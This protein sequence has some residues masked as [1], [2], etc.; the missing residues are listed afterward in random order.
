[1]ASIL[2][3]TFIASSGKIVNSMLGIAVTVAL[4][5]L[6]SVQE[7]GVFVVL[8]SYGL[9][10]QAVA[11]FGLYLVLTK[12]LGK[13]ENGAIHPE[14]IS[15]IIALRLWLLLIAFAGAVMISF[16][17]PSVHQAQYFL[18]A[19]IVGLTVQSLSQL[20][21]GV[22]QAYQYMG[23][24]TAGDTVGRLAQLVLIIGIAIIGGRFVFLEKGLLVA[25]LSFLISTVA[26]YLVHWWFVPV[27]GRISLQISWS[28]AR[29]ILQ[30]SWPLALLLILN[31]V[32]FR[33]DMVMLSVLR[34]PLEV[35]YYAVA[36]R[37]IENLLFFPAMFGGLL[38]PTLSRFIHQ[39]EM[40]LAKKIVNQAILVG[41]MMAG[42]SA[43]VLL[44]ASEG[45]IE[46]LSGVKFLPA[47][48]L[49]A[50]LGL[51][52][53]IM[54]IGNVIGFVLVA[55]NKQRQLLWLY[56]GLVMFTCIANA[57]FIPRFGALAAAWVT[58]ATEALACSGALFL[59]RSAVPYR[60]ALTDIL[61]VAAAAGLTFLIISWLHTF[62]PIWISLP[63]GVLSYGFF[64]YVFGLLEKKRFSLLL[65]SSS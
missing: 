40:D 9:L 3:N 18:L 24:A 30:E 64:N 49:L 58:V 12:E 13:Q 47:A 23:P 10:F 52:L 51:A 63:I 43:A 15:N 60:L 26:A 28:V 29:N 57:I 61:F 59:A 46:L 5:R 41:L 53:A 14:T 20:Y 27:K 45:I 11:D 17:I 56:A 38:L 65:Q 54:M 16:F 48:P 62:S 34:S 39:S 44:S 1:M 2:T 25:V 37:I 19:I 31:M 36:Y 50:T 32:Y 8:L 6:L 21:M 7:Y 42:G 4:T 33:I 22:Y 55:A 35:G